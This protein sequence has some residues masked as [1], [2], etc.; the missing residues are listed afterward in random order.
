V[1]DRRCRF[2]PKHIPEKLKFSP[3]LPLAMAKE[4]LAEERRAKERAIEQRRKE[5]R[6]ADNDIADT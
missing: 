4:K 1:F 2:H 5:R 6:E 3:A